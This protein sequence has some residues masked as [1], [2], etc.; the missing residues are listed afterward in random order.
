MTGGKLIGGSAP[1]DDDLDRLVKQARSL[2]D[3]RQ[4]PL[5]LVHDRERNPNLP[6][7]CTS[8]C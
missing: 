5:L 6:I 2:L 7:G 1:G 8:T 4:L 3:I